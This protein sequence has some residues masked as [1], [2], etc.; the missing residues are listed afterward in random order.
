VVAQLLVDLQQPAQVGVVQRRL[1][2]V[3]DVERR[4]P[5]L[6]QRDQERHR[7][8][9][10]LTAGQQR[11]PLDLLPRRAGLDVD[12]GGQHVVGV[13]EHQPA[14]AAGEQPGEDPL[15]GLLDV[16]VRLGEDLLDPLVDLLDDVEQVAP[17]L[18]QVVEL[19]GQEPVPLL[20]RVVLLQRERVDPPELVECALGR[21]EPLGH[22]RPVVR[23]R[24]ELH[25]RLGG[26]GD[27]RQRRHR[28]VR[29]VLGDQ[30]VRLGAEIG[31]SLLVQLVQPHPLLGPDQLVAVHG[32]LQLLQLVGETAYLRPCPGELLLASGALGL[33][34]RPLCRGLLQRALQPGQDVPGGQVHRLRRLGL[35][36]PPLG[37]R[38]RPG[39][40]LALG[41]GGPLQ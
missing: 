37:A 38:D 15:E 39:P 16:A 18:L 2:L 11:Q 24:L 20:H 22:L 5:G 17:G 40:G 41:A 29:S 36:R 3:E 33:D 30:H 10:A 27:L 28:L 14:L 32:V 13:G 23:L 6:E 31:Q 19:F 9:R 25:H 21:P 7:D 8:Q 34:R 35:A 26:V 12:A 1:D 4:R